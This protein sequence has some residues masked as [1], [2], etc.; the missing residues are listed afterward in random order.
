VD[1]TRAN[2]L[3][4]INYSSDDSETLLYPNPTSSIVNW[5]KSIISD[6]II[7]YNSKGQVVLNVNKPE[8]NSL[9]LINLEKGI[10]F[11]VFLKEKLRVSTKKII[12][13]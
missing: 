4:A 8:N 7:I 2:S 9:S 3:N 12:K 10:Y 6:E 5:N 13:E 1:I 11:I